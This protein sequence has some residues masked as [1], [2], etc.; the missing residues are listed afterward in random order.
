MVSCS[1]ILH[2]DNLLYSYGLP[3]ANLNNA[4]G[5]DRSNVAWA[6]YTP[7]GGEQWAIGDV[8]TL[9]GSSD[10][11]DLRVWIVAED[12]QPPSSMWS[13]LTLYGGPIAGTIAPLSTVATDGS[14]PNVT[15]QSVTYAGGS[16]YQ[17]SSGSYIDIYQVDF[18]LNWGVDG[19]TQYGFFVGGTPTALNQSLYPPGVSPFLSASNAALSGLSASEQANADGLV[20]EIGINGS[21]ITPDSFDTNGDGWDKSSDVNVQLYGT[22]EPSSLLLL[23]TLA[24]LIGTAARKKLY[25]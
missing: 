12:S 22:P 1:G 9:G 4:A 14:D 10:I 20:W 25:N 5:A 17:G 13:D 24:V 7:Y 21:T 19:G 16:T 11:T 3:T 2:A 6:D 23:G 18:S 8:F 15:F